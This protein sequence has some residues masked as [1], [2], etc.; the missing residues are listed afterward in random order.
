ML[1][2]TDPQECEIILG[3]NISDSGSGLGCQLVD[4]ARVLDSGGVVQGGTDGNTFLV[5]N[6]DS[7]D[8]FVGLDPF[9]GFFYFRHVLT[10]KKGEGL[11]RVCL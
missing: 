8:S 10:A 5:Y 9:E 11:K 4:E 2:R 1:L 6:N 3:I 7:N